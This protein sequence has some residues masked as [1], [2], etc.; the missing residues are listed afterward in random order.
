M[1]LIMLVASNEKQIPFVT[2]NGVMDAYITK[3]IRL[4]FDDHRKLEIHFVA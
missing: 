2:I 1:Y 4:C 3:R